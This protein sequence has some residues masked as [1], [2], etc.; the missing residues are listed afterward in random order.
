MH[1]EQEAATEYSKRCDQY[2]ATINPQIPGEGMLCETGL[3]GRAAAIYTATGSRPMNKGIWTHLDDSHPLKRWSKELTLRFHENTA[4]QPLDSHGMIIECEDADLLRDILQQVAEESS[5]D[6]RVVTEADLTQ[7]VEYLIADTGTPPL[8]IFVPHALWPSRAKSQGVQDGLFQDDRGRQLCETL[9]SWFYR[10]PQ[11]AESIVV[12][13]V[14]SFDLIPETLRIPGCFD[15]RLTIEKPEPEILARAF[16]ECLGPDVLDAVVIASCEEIGALLFVE[17]ALESRRLS[18]LILAL[19]RRARAEQRL[20]QFRDIYEMVAFGTGETPSK[21]YT[22]E[23]NRVIAIHEAGHAVMEFLSNGL[24]TPPAYCSIIT[25]GHFAGLSMPNYQEQMV[26]TVRFNYA[27]CLQRIQV[28][29]AGRAAEHVLLG[30]KQITSGLSEADLDA[31]T[32]IARDMFQRW[33]LPFEGFS[34]DDMGSNLMRVDFQT[35]PRY[36]EFVDRKIGFFLREQYKITVLALRENKL[37]LSLI[38]DELMNKKSLLAE[39]FIA[40]WEQ[41]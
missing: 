36:A 23:M 35:S 3:K 37:K 1:Q 13:G 19:R 11:G 15:R 16:V 5:A 14:S 7:E 31:A 30:S 27:D 21:V 20:M 26:R 25:R 29:L 18:L 22:A 4:V 33:G 40:I 28:G 38:A 8:L 2:G 12:A 9:S 10:M 17:Y 41:K 32:Q 24:R 34:D 39:D 6:M